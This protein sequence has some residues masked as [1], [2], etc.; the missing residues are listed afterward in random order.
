M[1]FDEGHI[2]KEIHEALKNQTTALPL[3]ECMGKQGD[4]LMSDAALEIGIA[5]LMSFA[6]VAKGNAIVMLL[7]NLVVYLPAIHLADG[8]VYPPA[9][10]IGQQRVVAQ[11]E[12]LHIIHLGCR[13]FLGCDGGLYRLIHSSDILGR[14]VGKG[15]GNGVFVIHALYQLHKVAAL[16]NGVVVPQVLFLAYLER[17][18]LLVPEG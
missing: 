7:F 12:Q 11:W 4:V 3:I 17:C 5:H 15:I 8:D 2:R 1:L 18:G 14:K 13:V 10:E 9:T 16:L 6:Q